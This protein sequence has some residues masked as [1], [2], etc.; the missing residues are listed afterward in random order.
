MN[1]LE[2]KNLHAGIEGQKILKGVNLTIKKGEFH[3]LMGPNG[4]GKSTLSNVIMGSPGYEVYSGEIFFKE[5]N[6]M[7]MRP[8][9]RSRLGLFLSFQHPVP[10]PGVSVSKFLKR[11]IEV[12]VKEKGEKFQASQFIKS[13]KGHV[14]FLEIENSFVNRSLNE[15]FSGGEKKRMEMLQ[16]LMLNPDLVVLDELDSGLDIDAIK[17]V[18]KAVNK[19]KEK[20]NFSVFIITHYQRIL[21]YINP[22][23]V[24]VL[25]NGKIATS[26]G[27]E[28]V[29]KLEEQGYD[30]VKEK[31]TVSA[32]V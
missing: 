8:D 17:V 27:P 7:E 22:D 18:S 11:A 13:L 1:V 14:S 10:I 31:S 20:D 6:V 23:F 5:K 2:I 16:M 12:R 25:V 28:L 24:H 26:G 9:E 19:L 32:N 21:N 15:G 3:A 4:S 29:G 30:W